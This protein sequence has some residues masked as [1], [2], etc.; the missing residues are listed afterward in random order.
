MKATDVINNYSL[1]QMSR[2]SDADRHALKIFAVNTERYK[3]RLMFTYPE[4]AR[5]QTTITE[6]FFRNELRFNVLDLFS[7]FS[8]RGT[9]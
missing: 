2:D 1:V 6:S 5:K 4:T 9:K 8:H 7:S 3:F